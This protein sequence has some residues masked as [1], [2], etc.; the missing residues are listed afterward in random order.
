MLYLNAELKKFFSNSDPFEILKDLNGTVYRQVQTRKTFRFE[1]N[2]KSYFAKVH[3][4][5]GWIEIFKN[6]IWEC[7]KTVNLVRNAGKTEKLGDDIEK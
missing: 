1:H 4:G 6:F 3:T 5:V 2:G 7:I